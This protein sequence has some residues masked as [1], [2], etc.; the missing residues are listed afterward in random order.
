[1]QA[2]LTFGFHF[3]RL[4]CEVA[5]PHGT[6]EMSDVFTKPRPRPQPHH[7]ILHPSPWLGSS[8]TPVSVCVGSLVD[9]SLSPPLLDL[10][11]MRWGPG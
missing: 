6:V 4:R 11:P 10:E 5:P 7:F 8:H 3:I 2:G 1:M 9:L